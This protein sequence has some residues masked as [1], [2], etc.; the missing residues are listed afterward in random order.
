MSWQPDAPNP[1]VPERLQDV[2]SLYVT[3]SFANTCRARCPYCFADPGHQGFPRTWTYEEALPAWRNVAEKY[4]PCFLLLSGLEPLEELP[5]VADL[6]QHHYAQVCT[7]A[8]FDEEEL[9][10]LVDPD[11]LEIHPSFHPH[12]W[13]PLPDAERFFGKVERLLAH[14]YRVPLIALVGWPDWLPYWDEWVPRIQ[15]M[16]IMPNPVPARNTK[17]PDGRPLPDSYTEEEL[18]ILRRHCNPDLFTQQGTVP[19]LQIKACAAGVA[20]VGIVGSGEVRRCAQLPDSMGGQNFYRD[21]GF[22]LLE[23]PL[24]CPTARCMCNNLYPYHIQ[25]GD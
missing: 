19:P 13:K 6:L 17:R 4:G 16:G 11:R 23:E 21:G 2:C 18:T 9:Y 20:T 25:K 24:P 22:T 5:F 14:G 8:M 10:R 7:N 3:Y 12:L 1:C 15:S